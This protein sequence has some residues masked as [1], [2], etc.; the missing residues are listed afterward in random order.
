MRVRRSNYQILEGLQSD[1]YLSPDA[2]YHGELI[3]HGFDY[4]Q[5]LVSC[6]TT[7]RLMVAAYFLP[8]AFQLP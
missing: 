2:L 6:M 8:T 5:S 1:G 4:L 3:G 7:F